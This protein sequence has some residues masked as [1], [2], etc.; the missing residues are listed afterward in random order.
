MKYGIPYRTFLEGKVQSLTFT[1]CVLLILASG[2]AFAQID[3]S[4]NA[5]CG[6]PYCA[7]IPNDGKELGCECFDTVDN[8]GDGKADQA[9]P[10]CATYY[11]LTFVGEGSDCSI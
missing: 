5:N 9:D 3:C 10:N 8:D 6:D 2:S 11:G 7:P 1:F 4:K